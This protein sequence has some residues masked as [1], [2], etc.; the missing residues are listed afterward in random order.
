MTIILD[1]CFIL[2]EPGAPQAEL[3]SD[4][5]LIE[6]KSNNHPGQGTANRRFFFANTTLELLYI[7]DE[8]EAKN[9]RAKRLRFVKRAT[10]PKASPLGLILR[11]TSEFSTVPFAGW[12]YCP[13][14]FDKDCCF[15]VGD[16]SDLLQEPLCICMPHNLPRSHLSRPENSQWNLTELRVSVPVVRPSPTLEIFAKCPKISLQLD[17]PHQLELIFNGGKSGELRDMKPNLPLIIRW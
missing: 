3:L 6:G 8:N 1:H 9:G 12:Q 14:Y 11:R 17:R 15:Q 4:I 2:T 16:N 5:G 10:D 13:E 7:R